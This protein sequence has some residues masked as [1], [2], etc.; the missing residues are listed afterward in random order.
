MEVEVVERYRNALRSLKNRPDGGEVFT[1]IHGKMC[2]LTREIN[3]DIS[4]RHGFSAYAISPAFRSLIQSTYDSAGERRL[5]LEKGDAAVDAA[6]LEVTEMI[7]QG[8][9]KILSENGFPPPDIGE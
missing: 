7:H 6:V 2:D 8:L 9:T 3:D 1:E 5:R 4:Q